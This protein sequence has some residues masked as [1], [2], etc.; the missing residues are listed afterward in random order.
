MV[1]VK[2]MIKVRMKIIPFPHE[3]SGLR[4]RI[5]WGEA[6]RQWCEKRTTAAGDANDDD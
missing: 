1:V 6:T 3:M 2:M 4:T 5:A